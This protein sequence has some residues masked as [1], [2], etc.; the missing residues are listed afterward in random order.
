V[1]AC[2]KRGRKK[3]WGPPR[4]SA[5]GEQRR[6]LAKTPRSNRRARLRLPSGGKKEKATAQLVFSEK[7]RETKGT[8]R[9]R[10]GKRVIPRLKQKKTERDYRK[11]VHSLEGERSREKPPSELESR[12]LKEVNQNH[13]KGGDEGYQGKRQTI[14]KKRQQHD[15][16]E[17]NKGRLNQLSAEARLLIDEKATLKRQ[18]KTA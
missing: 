8:E 3:K 18:A 1:G 4:T 6:E 12:A 10:T 7:R 9:Y 14:E 17:I 5:A 16:K 2:Q 13:Y 15:R 11:R